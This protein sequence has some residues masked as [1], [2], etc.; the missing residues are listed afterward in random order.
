MHKTVLAAIFLSS[1]TAVPC[2]AKGH[3][4]VVHS[5]WS[6]FDPSSGRSGISHSSC[7]DLGYGGLTSGLKVRCFTSME[8]I[9][10]VHTAHSFRKQRPVPFLI[11]VPSLLNKTNWVRPDVYFSKPDTK[12]TNTPVKSPEVQLYAIPIGL[13]L[14][15]ILLTWAALRDWDPKYVPKRSNTDRCEHGFHSPRF[16]PYCNPIT[17]DKENTI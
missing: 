11:D 1:I 10:G 4:D 5:I 16:C 3:N 14:G 12:I 6:I 9:E 17:P 7:M 13:F 8:P 2:Q 15:A